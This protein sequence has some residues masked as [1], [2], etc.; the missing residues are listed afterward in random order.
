MRTIAPVI[1]PATTHTS[2]RAVGRMLRVVF[3]VVLLLAGGALAAP[4]GAAAQSSGVRF[5]IHD[6]GDSTFAFAV[7]SAGWVRRGQEGIVVDPTHRD[8]LIARFRV[9]D[10]RDGMGTALITGQTTRLIPTHVALLERPRVPF[11]KQR[12]FW[13]GLLIGAAAGAVAASH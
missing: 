8:A 7:G 9:I 12:G 1:A 4:S 6:I 13:A 5:D 2:A 3:P 10:V 11:Y